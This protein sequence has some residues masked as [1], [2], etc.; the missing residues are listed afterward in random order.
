MS[1]REESDSIGTIKVQKDRLWGAQ[2]Q[3]SLQN[4]KIGG[5][6]ERMPIELI[7]ALTLV[8]KNAAKANMQLKLLDTSKAKAIIQA[9]DEVLD[10]QWNDHFPLVVWQTGSGT[11]SNMNVNEVLANRAIQIQGGKPGDKSI[12]P[13]DDVNKGQSSNDVFPTAMHI[14]TVKT[15][16]TQLLASL[17]ALIESLNKKSDEFSKIIKI[18]RTHL[19]DA[20]PLTLGQEFS[21]YTSQ[22]QVNLKRLES[23]MTRLYPLTLGGTAVGTGLNTHPEFAK[24]VIS[25]IAKETS[26]PFVPS[27]NTFATSSGHDDLVEL[28]GLLK[29]LACSLMKLGNDIRLMASGPRAGLNEVFIPANEPG[30]SIMPG[31]VNPTQSEALTMVCAEVIGCDMAVSMGGSQGHFELN[32]FK[33][34][35]IFNILR[36]IRLLSDA[37]NSFHKHCI[38]GLKANTEQMKNNVDRSLMLVTALAPHIGYDKAAAIAKAAYQNKTTL[39]EEAIRLAYISPEEFDKL[40]QAEKMTK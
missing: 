11:Q 24:L 34:L 29:T 1:F 3:R 4:F 14:A 12:H 10:N 20:T 17:K 23:C 6:S 31:K 18:G 7:H 15:L 19:M 33:P 25:F 2:T 35:I 26:L 5:V 32:V 21:G 9:A 22:M 40:I 30:S 27:Y 13:N 8:K 16:H 39:R 37:C 36:A 28:S 38:Q